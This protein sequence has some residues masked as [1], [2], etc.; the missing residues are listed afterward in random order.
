MQELAAKPNATQVA[1]FR[2]ALGTE[3]KRLL[4]NQPTPKV[5]DDDGN[6]VEL[7]HEKVD[8]LI[9]MV[10]AAVNDEVKDTY[11]RFVLAHQMQK[12]GETFDE[13]LTVMKEL[14]KTCEIC[15]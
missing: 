7:D 2:I 12:E 1:L 5:K 14:H 3:A 8:T 4:R 10:G 9:E 15:D 11:E 13:Y 6:L